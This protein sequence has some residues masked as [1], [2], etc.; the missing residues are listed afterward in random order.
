MQVSPGNDFSKSYFAKT[1]IKRI[2]IVLV[3]SEK[4]LTTRI[5]QRQL[6]IVYAKQKLK[7]HT[8]WRLS[9]MYLD[10]YFC[11]KSLHKVFGKLLIK[12]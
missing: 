1:A 4:L 12:N 3:I 7:K 6:S 5:M 8:S 2:K 9:E 11:L 10:L